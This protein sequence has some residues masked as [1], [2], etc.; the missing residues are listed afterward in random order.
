MLVGGSR[1][2]FVPLVQRVG[3]RKKRGMRSGARWSR[4]AAPVVVNRAELVVWVA[5]FRGLA[6]SSTVL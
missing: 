3:R 2:P 5:G 4:E 6:E 1:R